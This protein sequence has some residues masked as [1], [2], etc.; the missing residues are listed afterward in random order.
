MTTTTLQKRG[1]FDAVLVEPIELAISQPH[2]ALIS[3]LSVYLVASEA[4]MIA[5]P[6]VGWAM[7]IG[8]EWA[9]LRGLSSGEHSSTPWCRRLIIAAAMLVFLYG[10]LWTLRQFGVLPH[11]HVMVDGPWS[12]AGAVALT[13][14]HIGTIGAVTFCSAMVH[15]DVTTAARLSREIELRQVADREKQ[16]VASEDARSRAWRDAKLEIEIEKERQQALLQVETERTR[17]RAEARAQRRAAVAA[18]PRAQPG[19][20]PKIIYNGVEYPSIQAAADAH[21]IS[22][23]AMSKRI[24]REE[25]TP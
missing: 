9:Y 25:P 14:I 16:L 17:L 18:Q 1:L 20:Q 3:A 11:D 8:A 23:Q 12:I 24:K 5:H 22:R 13:L 4:T 10:S 7:A 6:A 19:L 21:G 15:R 2:Q